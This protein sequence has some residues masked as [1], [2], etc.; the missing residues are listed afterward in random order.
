MGR[1]EGLTAEEIR[2]R[3]PDAFR[4]WMGDV[5][6][7]RFPEGESLDDLT[8]RAW[9][10]FERIVERH[11]GGAAAVIAHGGTNRMILCRVLGLPPTRL[12]SIGQ[13]YGALTVLERVAGRWSVAVMNHVEAVGDA[14]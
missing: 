10:A 3:E 5:A 8:A 11:A 12:L 14:D 13:D 4:D 9:P 1:W 2:A 6:G 7:Y